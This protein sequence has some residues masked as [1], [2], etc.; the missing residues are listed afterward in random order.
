MATTRIGRREF[1]AGTTGAAL[2]A[3]LPAPAIAQNKPVRI[4]LLTVKTGPLA[5]GGI[6][7]EQGTVRFLK[8]RNHMLAGRKVELVVADTG[9]TP[10]EPRRRRRS[11]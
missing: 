5:T 1:L 2:A 11:W 8:D 9:S 7:M 4:G 6:Q 3:T 10:L